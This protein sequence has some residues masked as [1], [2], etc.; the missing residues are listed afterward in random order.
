V[1]T[2]KGPNNTQARTQVQAYLRRLMGSNR[3]AGGWAGTGSVKPSLPKGSSAGGAGETPHT[4]PRQ[5]EATAYTKTAKQASSSSGSSFGIGNAWLISP[6]AST[7]KSILNLFGVGSST[8]QSTGYRSSSRGTF[9]I[10]EGISPNTGSGAHS[11]NESAAGLTGIVSSSLTSGGAALSLLTLKTTT[12]ATLSG[13]GMSQ[14]EGRQVL[15]TALRRS[16]SESRGIADV[17]SEFQD[18]L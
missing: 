8:N 3:Q 16:L 12:A 13:G 6:I 5:L 7:V 15:V 4:L 11:L 17:L 1:G 9:R 14:F 2:S 10:V 18:G